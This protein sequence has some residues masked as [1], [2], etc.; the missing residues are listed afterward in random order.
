M[1]MPDLTDLKN[2]VNFQGMVD[3]VKSAIDTVSAP[4]AAPT[5][6][7][8]A[9]KFAE[10]TALMSSLSDMNAQQAKAVA[11]IKSKVQELDKD[12]QTVKALAV[13][14]GVKQEEQRLASK[15]EA[16]ASQSADAQKVNGKEVDASKST[17]QPE[18]TNDS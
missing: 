3:N 14:V 11:N 13:E 7:A 17:K 5:N 4:K 2:K 18:S 1:K 9:A 10:I 6:D 16:E 8:L 12:I 15:L